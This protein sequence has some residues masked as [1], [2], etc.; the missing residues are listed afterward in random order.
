M[1]TEAHIQVCGFRKVF[2]QGLLLQAFWYV[3]CAYLV[4]M[5]FKKQITMYARKIT[6]ELLTCGIMYKNTKYHMEGHREA[7]VSLYS[8]CAFF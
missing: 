6:I 2:L 3:K 4:F 1:R 8:K 5:N 7:L